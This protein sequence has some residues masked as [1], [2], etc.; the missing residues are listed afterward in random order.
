MGGRQIRPLTDFNLDQIHRH[1]NVLEKSINDPT[2]PEDGC[3]I[4][5]N[6][7]ADIW[8]GRGSLGQ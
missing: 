5:L 8:W 2:L 4:S 3:S 7:A 6:T 1:S